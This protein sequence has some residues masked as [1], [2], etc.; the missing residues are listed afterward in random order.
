M[1]DIKIAGYLLNSSS[2]QYDLNELS[3]TYLGINL[4]NM[5]KNLKIQNLAWLFIQIIK[6][7]LLTLRTIKREANAS[8]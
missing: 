2:N 4:S 5:L 1:F 6:H 3:N 7:F 8:L